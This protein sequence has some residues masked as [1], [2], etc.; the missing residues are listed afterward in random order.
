[1]IQIEL[2][3]KRAQ[4]IDKLPS[5]E[6]GLMVYNLLQDLSVCV[7]VFVIVIAIVFVFV[8]VIAS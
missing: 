7:C 8:I 1:M 2:K 3:Q 4:M 6:M 5:F